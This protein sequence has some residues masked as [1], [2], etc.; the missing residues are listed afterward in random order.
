M[1]CRQVAGEPA[2]ALKGTAVSVPGHTVTGNDSSGIEVG[3]SSTGDRASDA[4]D[5]DLTDDNLPA[6]VNTW[7]ANRFATDGEGDGPAAGCV[8]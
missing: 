1:P 5:V 8:R 2:V 6:C 4:G 3:A 7:C